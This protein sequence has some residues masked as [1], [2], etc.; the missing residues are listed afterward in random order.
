MANIVTGEQRGDSTD[1]VPAV[2]EDLAKLKGQYLRNIRTDI[3][4]KIIDVGKLGVTARYVEGN[5]YGSP[6]VGEPHAITWRAVKAVYNIM[7]NAHEIA[8]VK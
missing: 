7:V 4:V 5:A 2:V 1:T 8:G 3:L 6:P